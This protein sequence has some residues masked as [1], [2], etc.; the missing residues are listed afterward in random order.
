[1]KFILWITLVR[2]ALLAGSNGASTAKDDGKVSLKA[3]DHLKIVHCVNSAASK[4]SYVPLISLPQSRLPKSNSNNHNRLSQLPSSSPPPLS[5]TPGSSD[6]QGLSVSATR[7]DSSTLQSSSRAD[8]LSIVHRVIRPFPAL[9]P[10]DLDIG[11]SSDEEDVLPLHSLS[12]EDVVILDGGMVKSSRA[13]KRIHVIWWL[14]DGEA[15]THTFI[16]VTSG[17]GLKLESHRTLLEE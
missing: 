9:P 7:K 6:V 5:P 16:P 11:D 14:K 2:R 1:M 8:Q 3:R 17:S 15:P 12:D 10:L 13:A 4:T